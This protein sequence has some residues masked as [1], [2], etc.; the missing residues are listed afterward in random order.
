M[1]QAFGIATESDGEPYTLRKEVTAGLLLYCET[2]SLLKESLPLDYF[3]L[4]EATVQR[5]RR[6]LEY[7]VTGSEGGP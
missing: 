2:F 5:I 7:N 3:L 1:H 4:I 6:E